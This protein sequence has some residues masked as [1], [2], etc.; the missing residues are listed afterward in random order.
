M[1]IGETTDRESI[2][3]FHFIQMSETKVV[4]K[5][6]PM[7]GVSSSYSMTIGTLPLFMVVLLGVL[8]FSVYELRKSGNAC[9]IQ[10]VPRLIKVR[11]E[12]EVDEGQL[13]DRHPILNAY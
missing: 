11:L 1:H 3:L 12:E 7:K 6:N 8:Q 5:V 9:R 10:K 13:V 2:A 4:M